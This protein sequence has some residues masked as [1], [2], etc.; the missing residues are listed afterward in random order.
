MAPEIVPCALAQS[1]GFQP[2][3][4]RYHLGIIFQWMPVSATEYTL[5]QPYQLARV[6]ILNYWTPS[7]QDNRHLVRFELLEAAT[8]M[9]SRGMTTELYLN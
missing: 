7:L 2:C 9:I 3:T 6:R 4:A 8:R 5:H 1:I